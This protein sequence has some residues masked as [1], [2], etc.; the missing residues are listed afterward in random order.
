[1]AWR[2]LS[3]LRGEAQ[4]RFSTTIA[5]VFALLAA[6]ALG[7][8]SGYL[9]KALSLPAAQSVQQIAPSQVANGPDSD[10]T[11]VLPGEPP[12]ADNNVSSRRGGIRFRSS[13]GTTWSRGFAFES[14]HAL[15]RRQSPDA[16][17]ENG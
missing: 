11:R 4:L 16:S 6:F 17:T 14:P 9:V 15:S 7:G 1:M 3:Q 10:L 5:V 8:G 13:F 2:K 12:A